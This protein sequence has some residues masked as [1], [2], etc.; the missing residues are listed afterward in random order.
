MVGVVVVDGVHTAVA[1]DGEILTQADFRHFD[2]GQEIGLLRPIENAGQGGQDGIVV[3]R[4]VS[5]L[6]DR[7][8]NQYIEPVQRLGLVRIN[9]VI[10]F[11]KDSGCCQ[12][13]RGSEHV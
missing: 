3:M 8:C 9:I 4:I 5:E 1:E 10:C 11:V 2:A 12:T 6:R 13:R 7:L